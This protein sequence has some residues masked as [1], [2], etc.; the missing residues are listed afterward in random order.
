MLPPTL[1]CPTA[2]QGPIGSL[3]AGAALA[4]DRDPGLGRV[5]LGHVSATDDFR[6]VMCI[7]DGGT[8]NTQGM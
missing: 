1:I 8:Q 7:D 6:L 2:A 4:G 3:C 5:D